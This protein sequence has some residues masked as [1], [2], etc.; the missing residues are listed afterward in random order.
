M[1]ECN[2]INALIMS[3]LIIVK[4][5]DKCDAVAGA[6]LCVGASGGACVKECNK[7]NALIMSSSIKLLSNILTSVT[8]LL[9]CVCVWVKVLVR[10]HV[11][12]CIKAPLS[13]L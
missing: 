8:P 13:Y 12:T 1:K 10:V 4:H 3:S 5:F 6:C 2:K 11:N 7:I 9:V